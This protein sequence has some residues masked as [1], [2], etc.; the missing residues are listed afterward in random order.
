MN[1]NMNMMQMMN[2]LRQ[3]PGEFFRQA[4][5]NVPPEILNNPRAV[6]EHLINSGQVQVPDILKQGT[7]K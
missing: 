6:V 7:V 4:G 2:M 5:V 1:M 3:N